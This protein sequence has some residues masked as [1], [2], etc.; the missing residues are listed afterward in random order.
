MRSC[1]HPLVTVIVPVYKVEQYLE[2]CVNSIISQSYTNLEI[3]LVDDGSPDRCPAICDGYSQRDERIQVI[4]KKNGGLSSARNAGM[5]ASN[6]QYFCFVDSD[7]YILPDMIE[8]LV[9]MVQAFHTPISACS[10]SSEEGRLR[11]GLT[12]EIRLLSAAEA[13]REILTDGLVC[14][15]AWAKLFDR[16]LFSDVSFPE[17]K[18]FEDYATIYKLFH[19]AGKIAFADAAKY[20]YTPN[21]AGITK[22]SFSF[23]QMDYFSVSDEIERFVKEYYPDLTPLVQNREVDMAVSLYRK[24][25]VTPERDRFE[26]ERKTLVRHIR[27]GL[28]GFFSSHYPTEKKLSSLAVSLFPV[29]T[30]KLFSALFS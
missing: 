25:S 15:S 19:K 28:F 30:E 8:Q 24:L 1:S 14:T 4:H 29:L 10:F 27:K 17:G 5:N 21:Y 12:D 20:Y 13:L 7:D 3:I 22:S 6:G 11:Q 16:E 9:G 26:E 2:R 18:I 23:R